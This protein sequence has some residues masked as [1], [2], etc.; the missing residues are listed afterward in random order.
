MRLRPGRRGAA[1]RLAGLPQ[2]LPSQSDRERIRPGQ[3]WYRDS[4][5]RAIR[6]DRIEARWENLRAS[7][8]VPLGRVAEWQTRTVQVRVSV[9]TWGFNSPLAHHLLRRETGAMRF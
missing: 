9:R 6:G 2:R 4:T 5:M 8:S 7:V 3:R 1:R